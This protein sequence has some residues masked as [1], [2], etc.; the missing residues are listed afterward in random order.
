MKIFKVPRTWVWIYS[1]FNVC[2]GF[3]L[4]D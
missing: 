2:G 1:H 3:P 4:Q